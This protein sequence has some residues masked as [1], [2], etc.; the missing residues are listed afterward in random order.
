MAAHRRATAAPLK[1]QTSVIERK[2]KRLE[3]RPNSTH[4][5]NGNKIKIVDWT[6]FSLR[7]ALLLLQYIIIRSQ[8]RRIIIIAQ[9]RC[10]QRHH[11]WTLKDIYYISAT[12]N[13]Q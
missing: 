10:L 11:P 4:F 9:P 6:F 8:S 5:I 12:R 3:R 1:L 7:L 2:E 13:E